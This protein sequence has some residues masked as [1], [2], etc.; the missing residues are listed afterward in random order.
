MK[1]IKTIRGLASLIG[2]KEGK[3]SQARIGDIREILGILSD[4][5]WEEYISSDI[6]INNG[7]RRA[8]KRKKK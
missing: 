1:Q 6:L 5:F 4:L 7:E 2:K 8:R 3:R